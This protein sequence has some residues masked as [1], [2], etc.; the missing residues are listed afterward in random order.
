MR[1]VPKE[2]SLTIPFVLTPIQLRYLA[3]FLEIYVFPRAGKPT[4]AIHILFLL[5]G[6][7]CGARQIKYKQLAL[8]A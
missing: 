5:T 3:N 1:G 6:G 7:A 4:R 2:S 8:R